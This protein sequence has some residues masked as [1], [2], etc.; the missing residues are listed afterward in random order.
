MLACGLSN[1]AA[2]DD[3]TLA[4]KLR[5][6]GEILPLEN[7]AAR[8]QAI[9]PGELLETE[10]EHKHGRYIYEVEILDKT[11]QVWELKL[12]ARTAELLKLERDD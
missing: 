5:A 9:K 3:Q 10:L 11:G 1:V 2:D 6:S 8:A 12:D 7:I 4:R